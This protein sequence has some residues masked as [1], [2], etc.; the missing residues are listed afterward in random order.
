MRK[1]VAAAGLA[2]LL[3]V[4]AQTGSA[5]AQTPQTTAYEEGG[6]ESASPR[7]SFAQQT[8]FERSA[9]AARERRERMESH[10]WA[11]HSPLRPVYNTAW[12]LSNP[13]RGYWDHYYGYDSWYGHAPVRVW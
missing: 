11:G 13:R 2:G 8:V 10:K 3:I 9:I 4:L 5:N 1:L 6:K 7:L 12:Y